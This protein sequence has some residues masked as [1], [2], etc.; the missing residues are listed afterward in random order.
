MF[1]SA[2]EPAASERVCALTVVDV[3][4]SLTNDER[5]TTNDERRTTND[6]RR[7]TNDERRATSDEQLSCDGSF[8]L[9]GQW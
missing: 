7:T 1:E 9:L 5:R 6:E 2:S 8:L 4:T 3:A